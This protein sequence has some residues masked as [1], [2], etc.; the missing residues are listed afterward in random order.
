MIKTISNF[1]IAV[2]VAA[3]LNFIHNSHLDDW[4]VTTTERVNQTSQLETTSLS[5]PVDRPYHRYPFKKDGFGDYPSAA[6]ASLIYDLDSNIFLYKKNSDRELPIASLTKVMTAV[7]ILEH[8]QLSE[9]MTIP[10]LPNL[11]ADSQRLGLKSGQQFKL[12]EAMPAMLIYSAND[13]AEALA[14]WDSGSVDNFTRKMN[15]F[16]KKWGMKNS[17]FVNPSGLDAN[18]HYSSAEDLLIL[19]SIALQNSDFA[20]IVNTSHYTVTSLDNQKYNLTSTNQLLKLPT[21]Y[22]VKTG[23]TVEAGQCLIAYYK[24]PTKRLISIVLNS[25]DRFQD[26]KNMLDWAANNY[27]WK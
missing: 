2:V 17:H 19:T 6:K 22:G 1:V 21:I 10:E 23:Q 4:Q 20:T 14:I 25:P 12:A 24:D 7:V 13:M 16:A 8:H 5:I 3:N 11:D 9:T 27:T 18:S 15:D 26:S